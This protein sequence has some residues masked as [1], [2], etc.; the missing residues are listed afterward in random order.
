MNNN[1]CS[2]IIVQTR[3]AL[4]LLML[5]LRSDTDKAGLVSAIDN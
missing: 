4:S 1:H 2:L 5:R 3:H